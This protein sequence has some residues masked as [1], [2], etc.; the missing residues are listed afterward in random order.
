MRN[1]QLFSEHQILQ[2]AALA[3]KIVLTSG[4]EV[5]RVE[6]IIET[7]GD[8]FNLKIDSFVTLTCI[9]IS[10]K[11]LHSETYSL[12]EKIRTRSTNLNKIHR[13]HILMNNISSYEFTDLKKELEAIDMEKPY[14]FH[15]NLFAS[16]IGAASFIVSFKGDEKD[17]AVA[18][19]CG[20]MMSLFSYSVS[21]LKLNS[22]FINLISSAICAFISYSFYCFNVVND[23]SISIISALMLLVPGVPFINSI[24]DIIAGDLV[25]G[26]SRTM[27]VIMTGGAIALG[28]GMVVKFFHILLG[29]I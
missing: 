24:R 11:T 5:Y 17:F 20:I 27:E 21:N 4:G 25:S 1:I 13:I 26:T 18:F 9:I 6:E 19:I 7:I 14:N 22:F 28:A 23:P 16:A 29:G 3:G 2:L 15:V 10:G 12:V 8:R